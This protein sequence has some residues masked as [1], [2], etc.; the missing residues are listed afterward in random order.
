ME[1]GANKSY[2]TRDF[3]AGV[4]E[5]SKPIDHLLVTTS[6]QVFLDPYL[7]LPCRRTAKYTSSVPSQA[8]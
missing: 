2:A 4:F 5:L 1:V 3:H 8:T 6:A 7:S